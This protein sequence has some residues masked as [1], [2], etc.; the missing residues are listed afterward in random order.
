MRIPVPGRKRARE[1]ICVACPLGCTLTVRLKAGELKSVSGNRCRR[2][3]TYAEQEVVDPRR[4]V[5]TTVSLEGGRI[6]L[7]P[8]KTR[9]PVPR[10][11]ARDV[12]RAAG[13]VVVRAPVHCGDTV[14]AD[15]CGSGVDLVATR[16][17]EVAE[18][19]AKGET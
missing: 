10:D 7:L 2:G 1:F 12:V 9:A 19:A 15:V 8:V 11:S 5:T 3:V 17:C 16:S 6:S 14:L 18:G 4:I 13:A